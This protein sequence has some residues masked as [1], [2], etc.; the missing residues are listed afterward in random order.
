MSTEIPDT[1]DLKNKELDLIENTHIE[2]LLATYLPEKLDKPISEHL[3]KLKQLHEIL[4]KSQ[5]LTK[6]QKLEFCNS[7]RY[8]MKLFL[9]EIASRK[10]Q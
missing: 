3:F 4:E 6:S 1:K 5:D 10:K 8:L 9:K 7:E 2:G